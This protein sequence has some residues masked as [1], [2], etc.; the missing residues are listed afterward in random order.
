MCYICATPQKH[1]WEERKKKKEET[2]KTFKKS[3][4]TPLHISN[5]RMIE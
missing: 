2:K 4:S 1:D 5:G 3:K